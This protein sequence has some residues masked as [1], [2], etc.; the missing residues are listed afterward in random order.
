ML[1]ALSPACS[2]D[3]R[4]QTLPPVLGPAALA[5]ILCLILAM[6][7]CQ[8]MGRLKL[9]VN[10]TTMTFLTI[11]SMP[12]VQAHVSFPNV[13]ATLAFGVVYFAGLGGDRPVVREARG[14]Q[15][16]RGAPN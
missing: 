11:A 5:L 9:I 12:L 1:W 8:I 3:T 10:L 4:L 16:E 13:F 15:A 7:Y 14:G 2:S 6:V